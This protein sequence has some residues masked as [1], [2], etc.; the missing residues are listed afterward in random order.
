MMFTSGKNKENGY[1]TFVWK[2]PAVYSGGSN[3]KGV[4]KYGKQ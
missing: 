2:A 3:N 4:D 1:F